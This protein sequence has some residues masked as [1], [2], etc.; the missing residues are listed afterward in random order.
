MQGGLFSTHTFRSLARRLLVRRAVILAYHRV[1]QVD[2][3]PECLCVE[4]DRFLEQL[5]V[6]RSDYNVIPLAELQRRLDDGAAVPRKAVVVTFDDGYADN[7]LAAKPLL[8]HCDVP[9][10]CFVTSGKLDQAAEFWWDELEHLL[11]EPAT[12]P[13][14][15]SLQIDGKPYSWSLRE[16][17]EHAGPVSDGTTLAWNVLQTTTPTPR[18]RAYKELAAILRTHDATVQDAVMQQLAAWAGVKRVVRD[19][20]R[21]MRPE[22]VVSLGEGGLVEVGAHTVTHPVLSAR[23]PEAQRREIENAKQQ[24]EHILN[25]RVGAFAYPFGARGDYTGDTVRIV[26]DAR[27]ACACSNFPGWVRRGTNPHELP[28]YL[29]RNWSGDE[30]ARNLESWYAN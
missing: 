29:V 13:D 17:P 26:R 16:D 1:T 20:H 19:T 18:Q 22:E 15:L 9:A 8:D 21:P 12:L 14:V 25:R 30:F 5:E 24:L 28:R 7:L 23:A 27:F 4:P 2:F 6:L 11:L 3:D 10:T